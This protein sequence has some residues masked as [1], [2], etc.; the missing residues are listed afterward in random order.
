M[1]KVSKATVKNWENPNCKYCVSDS[2]MNALKALILAR[3]NYI[4]LVLGGEKYMR[5]LK[6]LKIPLYYGQAE[7]EKAT[8][9]KNNFRVGNADNYALAQRLVELGYCIED[10]EFEYRNGTE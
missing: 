8:R 4:D 3:K 10:I 7:Y 6:T 9:T 5:D 2:E 1:L